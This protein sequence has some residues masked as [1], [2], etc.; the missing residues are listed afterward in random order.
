MT[1]R[2]L[3]DAHT[4]PI[5]TLESATQR[6]QLLPT[7]GGSIAAWEWQ[8]AQQWHPLLRGWDGQSKDC[9]ATA[10]FPLVPWSNR[11]TEGEFT[12][13]GRHYPVSANRAGEQYPIHGDGWQ[14]KWRVSKQTASSIELTLKSERFNGNPHVYRCTQTFTLL[15]DGLSIALAVTHLG[16]EALPYGL[17]LHPYFPRNAA[18]S[19]HAHTAGVMLSGNDCIPTAHTS[20]FPQTWDYNRPA[21]MDGPLIDNCFTGWDGKAVV[22]QPERGLQITMTSDHCN[23]YGL[24]YRP[25]GQDF[26]CFEPVTHPIDAF[27]LSGKPGLMTLAKGQTLAM[28]T[29]FNVS[30]INAN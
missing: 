12:H 7:L 14:Q 17:G 24:L 25:P 11:I 10:C 30:E 1:T 5:I 4:L 18:T 22:S 15:D 28:H 13:Q 2:N 26:F 19:F 20:V 23:G 6:L 9:T 29:T 27:H 3:Q 8:H 16:A 21:A